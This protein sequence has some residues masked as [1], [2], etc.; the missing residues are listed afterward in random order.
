V[1]YQVGPLTL[2]TFPFSVDKVEHEAET[3][4][5]PRAPLA[6]PEPPAPAPAAAR[7]PTPALAAAVAPGIRKQLRVTVAV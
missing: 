1:L 6:P 7:R 5:E 2:D 3:G 4:V